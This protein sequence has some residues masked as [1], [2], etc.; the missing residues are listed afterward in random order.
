MN[1]K[2]NDLVKMI[3]END[4][5]SIDDLNETP[6]E[7]QSKIND[8]KEYLSLT[9][10]DYESSPEEFD[11]LEEI[12]RN[13]DAGYYEELG[14][15]DAGDLEEASY[16]HHFGRHPRDTA[17]FNELD[18]N[19]SNREPPRITKSGKIH[20]Q[21]ELTRIRNLRPRYKDDI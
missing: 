2:Y 14:I 21:D 9:D 6:D 8:I 3:L 16:K 11:R 18:Y 12:E 13:A 7:N 4:E 15:E 20:K 17:P 5:F 10:P 1:L 19:I